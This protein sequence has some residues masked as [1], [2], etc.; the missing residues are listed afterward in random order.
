MKVPVMSRHSTIWCVFIA[1]ALFAGC[2][3]SQHVAPQLH[4]V[5]PSSADVPKELAKVVLPLYTIE[6]PDILV[7]EAIHVVPKS[8][9]FLR[10][11]DVIAVNVLGTLPDAP[12]S[13]AYP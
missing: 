1:A 12:I 6:P 2:R 4:A 8:P 10:T 11:G 9:Y 13:G 5:P 7:V 3:T